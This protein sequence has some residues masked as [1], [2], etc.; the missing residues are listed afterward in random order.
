MAFI[1]AIREY[2]TT[3]LLVKNFRERLQ[4]HIK[5][6]LL[7][8]MVITVVLQFDPYFPFS[9]SVFYS[10]GI[11]ALSFG[12]S[13][14]LLG[15]ATTFI[16]STHSLNRRKQEARKS[17][18]G[19]QWL[20]VFIGFLIG[21]G[22]FVMASDT[23]VPLFYPEFIGVSKE[24]KTWGLFIKIL[25]LWF[26]VAFF[27]F[28]MEIKTMLA[29]SLEQ[30]QQINRLLKQ[31]NKKIASASQEQYDPTSSQPTSQASSSSQ[32]EPQ[33]F[34]IPRNNGV[35]TLDSGT[36]SHISV[37][38]HYSRIFVKREEGMKEIEVRLSLKEALQQLPAASFVQIHRA[39][40][41]NMAHVSH[42]KQS[43]RTYQVFMGDQ[44]AALPMSRHRV[45]EVIPKLQEF[46][47]NNKLE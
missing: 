44:K 36:I 32:T 41:I 22:V 25:P 46:L 10:W 33:S 17:S 27:V 7:I 20:L 23:L 11:V 13:Q 38:E 12:G 1:N 28:E 6:T 24:I 3:P 9:F 8:G 43:A 29:G 4:L 47:K 40:L 18:V 34:R 5:I 15:E 37:E 42:I 19:L 14:W 45:P 35:E 30:A 26:F 39:H 16:L 21:Y 2:W 31:R